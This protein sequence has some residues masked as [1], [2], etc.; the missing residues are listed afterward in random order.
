MLPSNTPARPCA[1]IPPTERQASH[2]SIFICVLSGNCGT[3]SLSL[4]TGSFLTLHIFLNHLYPSPHPS[5]FKLFSPQPQPYHSMHGIPSC[6]NLQLVLSI[7]ETTFTLILPRCL[8]HTNLARARAL[9]TTPC[10]CSAVV[11][12]HPLSRRHCTSYRP[13]SQV[14]A[15]G[16]LI[17]NRHQA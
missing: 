16:D 8:S 15:V 6:P 12:L 1:R 13:F 9:S 11:S 14:A 5:Q 2:L 10:S 7:Q 3:C 17:S 4:H